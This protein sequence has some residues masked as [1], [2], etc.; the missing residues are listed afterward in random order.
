MRKKL[1]FSLGQYTT[2]FQAKVHVNKASA[3]ENIDKDYRNRERYEYLS[4]V[5]NAGSL[6]INV[7][8]G[9]FL[10]NRCVTCR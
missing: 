10:R 8:V 4:G 9:N 6:D 3:V 1:I 2:V 7:D 5:Q